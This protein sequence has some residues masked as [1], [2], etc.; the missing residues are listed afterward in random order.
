M[1]RRMATPHYRASLE[2]D[3]HLTF[4]AAVISN[5]IVGAMLGALVTLAVM[6]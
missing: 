4:A 6:A 2:R 5:L 3:Q 1:N